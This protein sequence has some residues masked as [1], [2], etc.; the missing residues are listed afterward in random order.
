M[1][2][3]DLD[4]SGLS[5]VFERKY[6]RTMS[7]GGDEDGDGWTNFQEYL[8][9]TNPNR[10]DLANGLVTPEFNQQGITLR[11]PTLSGLR[12][13]LELS[14]NLS[15]WK[16]AGMELA[17]DGTTHSYHILFDEAFA[18]VTWRLRALS[19]IDADGDLLDA[20]E[21][22]ETGGD[23]HSP[24]TDGDG[25]DDAGEFVQGTRPDVLDSDGDFFSDDAEILMGSDPSN[26]LS[27]PS[28]PA[29]AAISLH[30]VRVDLSG[31]AVTTSVAAPHL[32]SS[33][34][35]TRTPVVAAAAPV[36]QPLRH[37]PAPG[38]A[39]ITVLSSD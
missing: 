3:L 8:L 17:G 20:W 39:T 30:A 29:Y 1:D 16:Q 18:L 5:D 7:R 33:I 27:Y 22:A 15:G 25:I 2:S 31:M 6:G 35:I 38:T 34:N 12:Y 9:G 24:D 10:N 19:P 4:Q 26:A 23:P 37:S 32:A 21:E 36:V 13:Q 28:L 11:W 14:S